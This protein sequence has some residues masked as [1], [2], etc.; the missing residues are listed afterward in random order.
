MWNYIIDGLLIFILVV[1]TIV[2]IAKGFFDSIL[3]LFGTG[4]ALAVS[5]F[6]AK[7]VSNF[8]NKIF[9][10]EE[11][12]LTKIDEAT[13]G[14]AITIFGTELQNSDV[15][16]FV[17]W[18][19]SLIIVFLIVKLAIY[20]LSKI[21][22]SITKNSPALSGINRVLGMVFGAVRG[23]VVV[24][25]LLA[26]CSLLSQVPGIGTPIYEKISETKITSSVYKYVDEFVEKNLTEEKIKDII[27]RIVSE[28]SSTED[29]NKEESTTPDTT[30]EGSV[31]F[32][33]QNKTLE[34]EAN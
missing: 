33:V 12:I 28:A 8:I 24:I 4:I 15:A 26:V 20:I 9:N 32:I 6:T 16:K 2:G 30:P 7:Y 5:I 27:D 1:S 22:E 18:I 21:F 19:I 25:A 11:L 13:S 23:G 31:T 3:S 34:E 17:V 14:S 29:K 10:F